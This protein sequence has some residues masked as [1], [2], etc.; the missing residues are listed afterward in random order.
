MRFVPFLKMSLLVI[1]SFSF[2]V[3]FALVIDRL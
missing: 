3:W 2:L 1:S